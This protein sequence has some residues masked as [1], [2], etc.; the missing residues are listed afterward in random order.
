[1][2][3]TNELQPCIVV[4]IETNIGLSRLKKEEL[5]ILSYYVVSKLI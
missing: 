4:V 5:I 1:M 3:Y 2:G